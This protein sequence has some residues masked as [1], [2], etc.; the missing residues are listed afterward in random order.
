MSQNMGIDMD[1]LSNYEGETVESIS[2]IGSINSSNSIGSFLGRIGMWK[3]ECISNSGND[4]DL[5]KKHVMR[6]MR[7]IRE[8]NQPTIPRLSIIVFM[9]RLRMF[10]PETSLSLLDAFISRCKIMPNSSYMLYYQFFLMYAIFYHHTRSSIDII[11]SNKID[12][13]KKQISNLKL[14]LKFVRYVIK[15]KRV[16]HTP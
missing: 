11:D 15:A 4:C 7:F 6:V 8:L 12:F 1:D 16:K 10:Y 9:E 2:D 5:H 13:H 14:H 3:K